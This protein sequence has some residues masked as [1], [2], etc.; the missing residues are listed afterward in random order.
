MTATQ[1]QPD[2][3]P[4]RSALLKDLR[5]SCIKR[6]QDTGYVGRRRDDATLDFFAGARMAFIL[7]CDIDGERAIDA[8]INRVLVPRGFKGLIAD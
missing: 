5:L 2:N 6:M 4:E 7:A 3:T 8:Y 1:M